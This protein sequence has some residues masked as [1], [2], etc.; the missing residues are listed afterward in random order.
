[1]NILLMYWKQIAIAVAT[2]AL[3]GYTYH[4]GG[5]APRAE[6]KAVQDAAAAYKAQSER[7]AKEKNDEYAKSLAAVKSDWD[8]FRLRKPAVK[9]VRLY[10]NVCD[11]PSGNDIVSSAV[12]SYVAEVGR[13]R[14]E[15]ESLLAEADKQRTQLSCAVSWAGTINQ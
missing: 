6:L 13:F 1:M 7:I 12:S 15:V 3:L 9:T 8:A 11:S 5:N 4:A 10:T 14:E 2:I